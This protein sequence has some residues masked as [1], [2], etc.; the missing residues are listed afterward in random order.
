MNNDPTQTISFRMPT[1]Y[2]KQLA[3][4]G[5]KQNLSAGE[6]AR[7]LVLEVL[8]DAAGEQTRED[9]AAL[10]EAVEKVREDL[11][12]ATAALLVNAGKATVQDA[13]DWARKNLLS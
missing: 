4:R 5:A 9:V 7:R 10:R 12:T 6:Q 3:E 13:Q 1:A 2:A 11:A 8:S